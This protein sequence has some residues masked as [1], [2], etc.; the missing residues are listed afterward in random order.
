MARLLPVLMMVFG[1]G[2]L[3][4]M[5]AL[6]KT[7]GPF[8]PV[9]QIT[10]LRY[11]AGLVAIVPFVLAL[12]PEFPSWPV[13]RANGLRGILVVGA[14]VCFFKAIQFIPLALATSL[15][16]TA[17]LV[18]SVLGWVMLKEPVPRSA[19]VAILLGLVGVVVICSGTLAAETLD[20]PFEQLAMG[21]GLAFAAALFYAVAMV[22]IR[23]RTRGD[24][25]VTIIL[26]QTIGGTV[27]SALPGLLVWHP[28]QPEHWVVY[29][30]I[31]ACGTS[32]FFLLSHALARAPVA[33]LAPIEYSA[34]LWASLWGY[35]FFAEMPR[36]TTLVGAALIV[37]AGLI[38]IRSA[39]TQRVAP[40]EVP[41]V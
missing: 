14:G 6:V 5:D 35:L 8:Y 29:A 25:I 7:I 22:T 34:F 27:V 16:F 30:T 19:A 41:P 12:R 32:G 20:E 37:V 2:I 23:A 26:M 18:I 40:A 39:K 17:P 28:I 31:G 10:F 21:L 13:I 38:V 36:D 15:F 4:L 1:I 9:W 33:T 24:P 11:V 3:S